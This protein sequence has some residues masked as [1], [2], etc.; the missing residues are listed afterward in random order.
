MPDEAFF[1]TILSGSGLSFVNDDGRYAKWGHAGAQSPEILRSADI[2]A[3]VESGKYFARKF[4]IGVDS[5]ALDLL[6]DRTLG[7]PYD[8][9]GAR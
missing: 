3:I 4:D 2:P 7:V 5:G 6:D 8:K 9:S 1:Q